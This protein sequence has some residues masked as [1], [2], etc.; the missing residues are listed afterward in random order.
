MLDIADKTGAVT[1]YYDGD[2]PFCSEYVRYL[3]LRES[4]GAPELVNVRE[5]PDA[6]AE[7]E[8]EGFDLDR[9]M[10]AD[11]SGVRY[12]GADALNALALLTTPSGLFNRATAAL[13]ASPRLSR[14][15]Y[16]ILRA[17]R[18]ATLTLLDR[19]PIRS[20]DI[21]WLALFQVFTLVFGL[22]AIIHF[23]IN[24]FDYTAFEVYPSSWLAL[25]CGVS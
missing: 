13:F 14:I 10:V 23:F 3:R 9:G 21:G 16:P 4:V 22:F 15:A 5:A 17:G 6:R 25:V 20:D 7:L 12:E 11:I 24:A 19:T 18:N 2:C 1:I 8:A